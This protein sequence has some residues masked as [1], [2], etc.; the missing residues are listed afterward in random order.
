MH[1]PWE[2]RSLPR[3][4]S[5]VGILSFQGFMHS[6]HLPEMVVIR[7]GGLGSEGSRHMVGVGFR[8]KRKPPLL[9]GVAG[10]MGEKSRVVGGLVEEEP[11]NVHLRGASEVGRG[12]SPS[13]FEGGTFVRLVFLVVMVAEHLD[14][15]GHHG[16]NA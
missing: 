9:L 12:D 2:R 4:Y 7:M 3:S 6:G 16:V 8:G 15:F 13:V 1:P 14:V 11:V 5:E 10:V